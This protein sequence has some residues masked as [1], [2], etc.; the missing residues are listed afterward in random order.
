MFVGDVLLSTS[1]GNVV[2]DVCWKFAGDVLLVTL[3]G[4]VVCDVCSGCLLGDAVWDLL[5]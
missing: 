1:F 3:S 4:S 2:C 5:L